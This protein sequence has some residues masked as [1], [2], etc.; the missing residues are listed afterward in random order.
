M[1]T[2]HKQKTLDEQTETRLQMI[3][4]VLVFMSVA[5]I[6]VSSMFD[7]ELNPLQALRAL[8]GG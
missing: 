3:A 1:S 4:C 2:F 6:I 7:V 8:I 5:A